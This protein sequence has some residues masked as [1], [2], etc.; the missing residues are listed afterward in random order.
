MSLKA[1]WMRREKE[2]EMSGVGCVGDW[3]L[4]ELELWGKPNASLF[5]CKH[6]VYFPFQVLYL[7]RSLKRARCLCISDPLSCAPMASPGSVSF[8]SASS[9]QYLP[10]T[11]SPPTEISGK[12]TGDGPSWAFFW[13]FW[14]LRSGG[15]SAA[16]SPQSPGRLIPFGR[17]PMFNNKKS[18][19][20]DIFWGLG[21]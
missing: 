18:V 13:L 16:A 4:V 3:Q 2:K 6:L 21:K 1:P 5:T 10:S 11:S 12:I 17:A 7:V 14:L 15:C 9:L 19:Q 8:V 20:P